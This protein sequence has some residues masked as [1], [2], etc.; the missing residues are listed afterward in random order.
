MEREVD[1]IIVGSGLVG[2]A[3]AACL[4]VAGL[5]VV[6]LEKNLPGHTVTTDYRPLT[7]NYASVQV[8]RA[9]QLW[10]AIADNAT[11]VNAVHVSQQ[12]AF[13][14]LQFTADKLRV[15]FLGQVVSYHELSKVLY[16]A[17]TAQSDIIVV[18][19]I[20]DIQLGDDAATLSFL[21]QGQLQQLKAKLIIGCDGLHS[22]C[23]E[24][25]GIQVK[26]RHSDDQ[27]L[28]FVV[29]L[30]ESHQQVARQRFTDEGS[31]ALLPMV[32]PNQ[33]RLVWTVSS[34]T[35]ERLQG[36]DS[37]ALIREVEQHFYGYIPPIQDI[38]F[39]AAYPLATLSVAEQVKQ[40]FVLLGNAAHTFYPTTAQGFN[41][42]LRDAAA[43]A[44]LVTEAV[45]E[46][47]DIASLS[48]LKAY[49]QWRLP[50]QRAVVRITQHGYD[51]FDLRLPLS[52]LLR[53]LG[54]AA[55]DSMPIIK[56]RIGQ[57]LLG[58]SGKV[59][60]LALGVALECYHD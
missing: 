17:M 3:A 37:V 54:L 55:V 43:L 13:G 29:S 33:Y 40:R 48:V 10:P 42:G 35:A 31:L 25:L 59:P 44:Q 36:L 39:M 50:D 45:S 12:H 51:C 15:P 46:E 4:A 24:L 7:L 27:A 6:V 60:L 19:T 2:A 38:A 21:Q 28:S 8:L 49:E 23:R 1:I 20:E 58:L 47:K 18:D 14:S 34:Q 30:S 53:G 16:Q 52:G 57:R 9:L 26:T 56:R 41:L 5:K 11:A 22:V 32:S